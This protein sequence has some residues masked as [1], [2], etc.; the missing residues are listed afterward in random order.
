MHLHEFREFACLRNLEDYKSQILPLKVRRPV[1]LAGDD[2]YEV[3]EIVRRNSRK[4]YM[5]LLPHLFKADA[6]ALRD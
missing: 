5:A 6:C 3:S 2:V 4:G 1:K